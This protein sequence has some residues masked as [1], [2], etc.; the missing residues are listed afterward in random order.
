M[1]VIYKGL[2]DPNPNMCTYWKHILKWVELKIIS[3][4]NFNAP[5][6]SQNV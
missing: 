4:I 1:V 6:M 5:K 3:S 2:P